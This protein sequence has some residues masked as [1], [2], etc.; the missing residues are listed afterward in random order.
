[1]RH[2]EQALNRI[3]EIIDVWLVVQRKWMYLE[4]IFMGSEDIR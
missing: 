1:M 2:W 3:S 4:G